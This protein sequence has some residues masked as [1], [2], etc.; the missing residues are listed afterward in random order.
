MLWVTFSIEYDGSNVTLSFQTKFRIYTP[1]HSKHLREDEWKLPR[2][3]LTQYELVRQSLVQQSS[4]MFAHL[5][6]FLLELTCSL[7]FIR[8]KY[9]FGTDIC[10]H[11]FISINIPNIIII[12]KEVNTARNIVNR[13]QKSKAENSFKNFIHETKALYQIILNSPLR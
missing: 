2:S 9:I 12:V 6:N 10:S 8:V 1:N 5:M 4:N 3:A 7:S 11:A 13:Q